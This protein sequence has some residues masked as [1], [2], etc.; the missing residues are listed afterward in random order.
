MADN[1]TQRTC[2]ACN[3]AN[4][5]PLT[6][7]S[8]CAGSHMPAELGNQSVACNT[9]SHAGLIAARAASPASSRPGRQLPRQNIT[10]NRYAINGSAA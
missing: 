7:Y 3:T 2:M 6:K 5:I 1:E 9:I 10:S 8:R 4:T